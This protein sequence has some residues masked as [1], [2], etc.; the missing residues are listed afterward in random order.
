MNLDPKRYVKM[1]VP[2]PDKIPAKQGAVV[3]SIIP[4]WSL[5]VQEGLWRLEVLRV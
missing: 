1:M 3:S 5:G 4:I 2:D